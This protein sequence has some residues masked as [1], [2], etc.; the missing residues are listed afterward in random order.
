MVVIKLGSLLSHKDDRKLRAIAAEN[1]ID[2]APP[3]SLLRRQQVTELHDI[4]QKQITALNVTIKEATPIV[5]ISTPTPV[6]KPTLQ[7][8]APIKPTKPTVRK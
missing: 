1:G 8:T 3:G 7:R 2:L 4:L 5:E 6:L